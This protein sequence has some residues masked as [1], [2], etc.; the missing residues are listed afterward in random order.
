MTSKPH[1]AP[2]LRA[3]T[4]A[5]LR[6]SV[7]AAFGD[8]AA[9]PLTDLFF[10]SFFVCTGLIM[11]WITYTTGHT[12]WLILA[13]MGFPLVGGLAALGFYEVSRR[14]SA[15]EG[16]ALGDVASVVWQARNGQ[17]PWLAVIIIVVFLFWFFLG[18]MIFALF[19]GLAPMTNVSTSLD[20]FLT[21]E[22]LTMLAFGS[23]VG[24]VFA[25]VVFSISVL[26]MPM[27]LDRDVDF[28]SALLR[29]ISAVH[30][31]PMIYLGWGVVVAVLTLAAMVPFFLGLFVVMPLLGHA[32]WHLYKSVTDP[33]EAPES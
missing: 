2:K 19:L 23:A 26:G 6:R 3:P 31:A 30:G 28:M 4:L 14:R 9:A 5:D 25:I 1:G 12:F 20:V 27:L 32:T 10:A 15:G 21:S 11:S 18:H 24:A 8:F 33:T 29:S 7:A 17:L 16:L 13:V 22:G